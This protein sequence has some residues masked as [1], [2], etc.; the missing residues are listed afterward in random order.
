MRNLLALIFSFIF[1]Q[2]NG[3]TQ[4]Q[5]TSSD[6]LLN[7]QKLKTVGSVLYIAAHPDDENTRLL[8]YLANEK[9]LFTVYLSLTRGDGGQNLIGKEHGELLGLIRTQELLEARKIDGAHQMFT[10]AVDFGFSKNPEE[11]FEKWNYDSVLYDVVWAI[12]RIQP[13]III[14]R[15]PTTGEGGHGHHTA[16]AI[17]AE[18]AFI[19]ASDENKFPDQLKYVQP[20]QARR[21]FWNTFNFSSANTISEDQLKLDIGKFNP[22][23]GKY[24]GEI[25]A[26][27]RSMHKSQGFG[28]AKS[29]G[30]SIEYFKQIKGDKVESDLFEGMVFDWDKFEETKHL[31]T[32]IDKIIERYNPLNPSASVDGLL[33]LYQSMKKIKSTNQYLN[34]WLSFKIQETEELIVACSGI[35]AE[36]YSSD[37]TV[38]FKDS[39]DISSHIVYSGN[40]E[41]STGIDK[42]DRIE[43]T[44]LAKNELKSFTGKLD[45]SEEY[46]VSD[47]Y[48]LRTPQKNNFYQVSNR[49]DIGAP[50][51]KPLLIILH[52][53]IND[54]PFDLRRTIKYKYVY[55]V[56]GEVTQPLKMLQALAFKVKDD[57]ILFPDNQAKKIDIIVKSYK[58]NV[59]GKLKTKPAKGWRIEIP[60]PDFTIQKKN[61]EAIVEMIISK[62]S[63]TTDD[64][65]EFYAESNGVVYDK[66]IENIYYDH[67][68]P[69]Y[70]LKKAELRPVSL[71]VNKSGDNIAYIPGSGDDV[72]D[73][74]GKAG[75]TVTVLD[76]DKIRTENLAIYQAVITGIRAFNTNEYLLN[77]FDKLMQ[78]VEYGGNLIVQ[79]N[80]SSNIGPLRGKIAPYRFDISRT[81]VTDENADVR[82]LNPQHVVF[83]HPNKITQNDFK[84]W[85]QERGLYFANNKDKAFESVLSMNDKG[86]EPHD[87]CLIIAKHG[88][89]NYVY[90]G[91][92]FF[93]QLPAGVPGAYRLLAN[94]ISLPK[95]KQHG[96]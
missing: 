68:Q 53:K 47:P 38:A 87:G 42:G 6:I 19:D 10:R 74:L 71:S 31:N 86:E 1:I 44:P 16:S 43:Y 45:F 95:N 22:L 64:V 76:S 58:N 60:N 66:I 46:S 79:Y 61:G 14:N 17:L 65:I 77:N 25:A 41:L 39:I 67:I 33:E 32:I 35:W 55:P 82:F 85:V 13:D 78:Y 15:F 12:R 57:I 83:N 40:V 88:K 56:R 49:N 2:C 75:Y 96:K 3:Q 92:S 11:T 54:V 4:Q 63:D 24:Y 62:T 5:L 28:A 8:T 81:R 20:W 84:G 69:Q 29:R 93:R 34:G 89:G 21:L 9:K 94:L 48:W 23:L 7:L 80:T 70:R 72:A 26:D 51:S 27:S 30:E 37:S 59:S 50:E 73:L 90:T 36:V 52:T 18:Q 91:L